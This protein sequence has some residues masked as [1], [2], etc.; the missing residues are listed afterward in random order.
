MLME[1]G[2]SE[3]PMAA[4]ASGT[5]VLVICCVLMGITV[6]VVTCRMYTRF[7]VAG[8]ATI[9]DWTSIA[10]LLFAGGLTAAMISQVYNGLGSRGS[11]LSTNANPQLLQGFH[12]SIWTYHLAMG[13]TRLSVILQCKRI[14]PQAGFG[15]AKW[16]VRSLMAIDIVNMLWS[17][18]SS[19]FICFPVRKF[20]HPEVEGHC[21]PRIVIW[22]VNSTTAM[23]LDIAV[24]TLALPWLRYLRLR[25]RHKIL[26]YGVFVLAGFPCILAI[27]RLQS[28]IEVATSSGT[29][30]T[31]NI[32]ALFSANEVYVAIICA[33][34][35]DLKA[36]YTQ[37]RPRCVNSWVFRNV[38]TFSCSGNSNGT[39]LKVS[40]MMECAKKIV[41]GWNS[42][43][44]STSRWRPSHQP[45]DLADRHRHPSEEA[46]AA[47]RVADE[48]VQRPDRAEVSDIEAGGHLAAPATRIGILSSLGSIDT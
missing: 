26:L 10:A 30:Y 39:R 40:G 19:M 20:W 22:L 38:S 18:F 11:N 12:H 35:P 32:L 37:T 45:V 21:F 3:E 48:V 5:T 29:P 14:F 46:D 24:A 9:D 8:K 41:L 6:L 25:M 44:S 33:C 1:N 23:V 36:F 7:G 43:K 28:L 17:F 16:L 34:L 42:G 47:A 2:L 4:R 27:I 15:F 13:F 31:D